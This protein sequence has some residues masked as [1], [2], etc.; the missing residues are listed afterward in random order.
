MYIYIYIHIFRLIPAS[1]LAQ[2]SI[3]N[4]IWPSQ[5]LTPYLQCDTFKR[6]TNFSRGIH[7]QASRTC[8]VENKCVFNNLVLFCF[9]SLLC[10]FAS[11]EV[12]YLLRDWSGPPALRMPEAGGRRPTGIGGSGRRSP[13]ENVPLG[14]VHVWVVAPYIH[15]Y[16]DIYI[17]I[18]MIEEENVSN[19]WKA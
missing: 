11:L 6:H 12:C 1:H 16:V 13:P 3:T 7:L 10:F 4:P 5:A 19:L 9:A 15:I 17:Y 2:N 18:Y 8:V 14:T